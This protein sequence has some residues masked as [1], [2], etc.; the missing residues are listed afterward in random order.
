MRLGPSHVL[1]QVCVYVVTLLAGNSYHIERLPRITAVLGFGLTAA[2][3]SCS[4]N[5]CPLIAAARGPAAFPLCR[6]QW[7]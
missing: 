5:C 2:F 7:K 6:A 1:A 3:I 4:Y